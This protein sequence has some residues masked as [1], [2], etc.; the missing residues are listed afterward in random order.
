[1]VALWLFNIML[2]F[3][4]SSGVLSLDR[5]HC[6]VFLGET[7]NASLYPGVQMGSN[8]FNAGINPTSIPSRRNKNIPSCFVLQKPGYIG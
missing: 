8:K 5:G 7:H 3:R 4:L 1:M 6:V 2:Y